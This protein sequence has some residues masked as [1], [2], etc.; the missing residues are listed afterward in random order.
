MSTGLRSYHLWQNKHKKE[1]GSSPSVLSRD[2]AS[3]ASALL[4]LSL[5]ERSNHLGGES[6]FLHRLPHARNTRTRMHGHCRV[7]PNLAMA[8]ITPTRFPSSLGVQTG[9]HRPCPSFT[10]PSTDELRPRHTPNTPTPSTSSTTTITITTT[11]RPTRTPSSTTV[12][13]LDGRQLSSGR[14]R[15]LHDFF[16]AAAAAAASG[17]AKKTAGK[18]SGALQ[19]SSA[20]SASASGCETV[21]YTTQVDNVTKQLLLRNQLRQQQNRAVQAQ[22]QAEWVETLQQLSTKSAR[23]STPAPVVETESKPDIS[24]SSVSAPPSPPPTTSPTQPAAAPPAST[25]AASIATTPDVVDSPPATPPQSVAEAEP[26]APPAPV[27]A[28]P[29]EPALWG[30]PDTVN[31]LYGASGTSSRAVK[32]TNTTPRQASAD[33]IS[34]LYS[35]PPPAAPASTSPTA[36]TVS[37][38]SSAT[39]QNTSSSSEAAPAPSTASQAAVSATVETPAEEK[40]SV[41]TTTD[42]DMKPLGQALLEVITEGVPSRP[43]DEEKETPAPAAAPAEIIDKSQVIYLVDTGKVKNL[44]VMKLRRLLAAHNLKTSGRKSELIARLTSFAR[45]K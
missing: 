11:T 34:S 33:S 28:T 9:Q 1:T 19:S 31:E 36:D 35:P 6:S 16:S 43:A 17:A 21:E 37:S 20:L 25:P 26:S 41:D 18:A 8:F 40:A 3:A 32:S 27:P 42:G 12:C 44:T 22:R 15:R 2:A 45:A 7:Q 38:S 24:S 13:T 29:V 30:S 4:Q 23:A 5:D 10:T 14:H 39:E